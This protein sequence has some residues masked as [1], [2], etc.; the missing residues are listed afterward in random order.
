MPPTAGGAAIRT[1]HAKIALLEGPETSLAYV[2]SANFTDRGW[3][4][5]SPTTKANVEA[6]ILVRRVGKDRQMLRQMIP[7]TIG[8]PVTLGP[9]ADGKVV[10][11]DPDS[12]VAPWPDFLREILLAP[13][14]GDDSTLDLE[15]RLVPDYVQGT[16]S[17]SEAV[18]DPTAYT[19]ANIDSQLGQLFTGHSGDQG[20]ERRRL[21]IDAALLSRLLIDQEV[22]VR[23]W[24]CHEGRLFPLNVALGARERLPVTPSSTNP[25]ERELI[26]YYQ[27]KIT[28]EEL[29]PDPDDPF[30]YVAGATHTGLDTIGV[31][32]SKIQS[33]Q[34][35]EF[36][37]ALRGIRDDLARVPA[38]VPG[39][40]M[41]L[42]GAISPLSLAASV[43]LAV[44]NERRTPVAA[45]FQ[46]VEI[47]ACLEEAR[48]L[49]VPATQQDD[50]RQVVEEAIGKVSEMLRCL[51][52]ESKP[53]LREDAGFRKYMKTIASLHNADWED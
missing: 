39:M 1:L 26:A 3:G 52:R 14:Q 33:Y 42:L 13:A 49:P 53:D 30:A 37:E 6:G 44:R 11:P 40:R 29:Y 41:S 12:M 16:W 10:K 38:T 43:Q 5:V 21:E 32:T 34:I 15:I 9:G 20:S 35:R 45:G 46:F 17:I 27:G 2:G 18:T 24:D 36:V 8:D 50:W 7:A 48:S 51:L 28:W 31:D 22:L 47:L 19:R 23:W 25:G 4:F